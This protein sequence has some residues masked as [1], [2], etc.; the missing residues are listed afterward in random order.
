MML[1]RLELAAPQSR[2]KHS[3]TEPLRSHALLHTINIEA[4]GLKAL[5]KMFILKV[6][7]I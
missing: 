4:V 7:G 6:Y 5:V 2:V 3:T 1:V